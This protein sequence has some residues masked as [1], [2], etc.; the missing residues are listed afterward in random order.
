MNLRQDARHLKAKS[1]SSM[2]SAM[3][4]FNS[5]DDDGRVTRVLLH[6]QHAFEMLLKAALVQDRMQVFDKKTGRSIGFERC[7]HEARESDRIKLTEPESGTPAQHRRH[8]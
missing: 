4:A 7:L 2:R 6:L 5:P 8:A 1:I 3:T